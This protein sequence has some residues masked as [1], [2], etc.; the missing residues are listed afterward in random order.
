MN[1]HLSASPGHAVRRSPRYGSGA[2]HHA[3]PGRPRMFPVVQACGAAASPALEV[4]W[5]SVHELLAGCDMTCSGSCMCIGANAQKLHHG[6]WTV[7]WSAE[8]I[9]R[10][11]TDTSI[12]PGYVD[13]CEGNRQPLCW[14]RRGSLI[15]RRRHSAYFTKRM[16]TYPRFSRVAHDD[17]ITPFRTDRVFRCCCDHS[18]LM[19]TIHPLL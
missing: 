17:E 2:C 9:T 18:L 1:D 16:L 14:A 5:R 4:E 3:T 6:F 7:G 11:G 15:R 12:I 19:K 13:C 10:E 8:K